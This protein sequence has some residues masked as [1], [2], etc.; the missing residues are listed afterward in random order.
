MADS[1]RMVLIDDMKITIEKR[2][3]IHALNATRFARSVMDS[4]RNIAKI[5]RIILSDKIGA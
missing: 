5:G 2:K 4:T 3:I 1:Q